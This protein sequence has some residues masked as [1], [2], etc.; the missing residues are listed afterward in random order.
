MTAG[1][2]WRGYGCVCLV[3]VGCSGA[4]GDPGNGPVIPAPAAPGLAPGAAGPSN[5]AGAAQDPPGSASTAG[6]PAGPV[7]EPAPG[8]IRRLTRRQLELSLRDLLGEVTLG[9]TVPDAVDGLPSVGASYTSLTDT[10][11]DGFHTALKDV[12]RQTLAAPTRWAALVGG[13]AGGGD[14]A[15]LR[16]FVTGFGR[17]AWRRPLAAAEIDRY[18]ALGTTAASKLGDPNQ[19]F[20]YAATGLLESPNFLY[21]VELGEPDSTGGGR[22]R[23]R[24][25]GYELASRMSY[26]IT[27][28]TPDLGLLDAAESK[29]LDTP[30][31]LRTQAA[32][33]LASAQARVGI[34]SFAR[35]FFALDDFVGKTTDDPRYTATLRAAMADE[36]VRLYQSRLEPGADFFDLVSTGK[37]F[38][39][40][41]LAKIY[42]I[43]GLTGTGTMEVT[44]PAEF[45]RAGLLG[46]GAFL[47]MTSND[48]INETAP[49]A[50]GLFISENILCREIP[51][52]PPGVMMKEPPMGVVLTKREIL[53]RHRSD[54]GCAACHGLFDPL[55]YAFE[56]FDWVGQYRDKEPNGRPV[57][58]TGIFDGT[59]FKNAREL[60][61]LLRPLPDVRRCFVDF[62]YRY[63]NGHP[64]TDE[65]SAT[66]RAWGDAMARAQG[67][68]P[69]FITELVAS[70]DF[71][72]VAPAP[73]LTG[74]AP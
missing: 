58:T 52:P 53:D 59:S 10:G 40:A 55:G 73:Q 36:V 1:H 3:A 67:Q 43:P 17:R 34:G 13:C 70:D 18:V 5:P 54:P 28:S 48:K 22:G 33:L 74:S 56:S 14:Q 46:T 71:R 41:E 8:R 64:A 29:Q 4:I 35:E 45:P 38:V 11:V 47:A 20:V 50:R 7:A 44:L 69:R 12:V 68:L 49:V 72:H 19:G 39:T 15:C 9:A 65:D 51:P 62:L 63:A 60:V 32:R 61:A 30:E 2:F 37:T 24:Y 21:R 42:G 23:Y 31:G 6:I 27:G 66:L 57:D 16:T 26:L 25:T